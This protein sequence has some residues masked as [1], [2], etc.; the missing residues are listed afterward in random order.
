MHCVLHRSGMANFFKAASSLTVIKYVESPLGWLSHRIMETFSEVKPNVSTPTHLCTSLSSMMT[1]HLVDL[2]AVEHQLPDGKRPVP[3]VRG[4]YDF[5]HIY[6][7]PVS[8]ENTPH[9]SNSGYC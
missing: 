1:C 5:L 4:R 7:F 3:D 9:R 8:V 6:E 2:S